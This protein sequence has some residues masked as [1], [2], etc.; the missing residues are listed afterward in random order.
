MC[1]YSTLPSPLF[2]YTVVFHP[3]INYKLSNPKAGA[4]VVHIER[5]YCQTVEV[6]FLHLLCFLLLRTKKVLKA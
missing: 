2:Y 6:K 4:Q 1:R 5:Y 3:F